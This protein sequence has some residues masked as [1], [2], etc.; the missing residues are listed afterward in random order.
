MHAAHSIFGQKLLQVH[1]L[2]LEEAPVCRQ[3]AIPQERPKELVEISTSIATATTSTAISAVTACYST[4]V[5]HGAHS[6]RVFIKIQSVF[7]SF[8]FT[9]VF[10]AVVSLHGV[11]QE[12]LE[13]CHGVVVSSSER[14]CGLIATSKLWA[15]PSW[16]VGCW[17]LRELPGHPGPDGVAEK[18]LE[19]LKGRGELAEYLPMGQVLDGSDL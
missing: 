3:S 13:T 19:Y 6:Q 11:L 18:H 16:E 5:P 10:Q 1:V 4:A 14:A 2:K 17:K 15:S 7:I 8:P 9:C 12:G